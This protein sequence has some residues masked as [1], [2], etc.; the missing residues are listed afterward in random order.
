MIQKAEMERGKN[1]YIELHRRLGRPVEY[2][3]S[4]LRTKEKLK[5]NRESHITCDG[6]KK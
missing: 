1:N 4:I 3:N 5:D 6:Q 2:K